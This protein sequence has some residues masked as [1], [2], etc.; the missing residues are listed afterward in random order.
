MYTLQLYNSLTNSLQPFK[1]INAN[2][3]TMYVCGPTVYNYIHVGNARPI[4]VFDVLFRLLRFIYGNNNVVYAT[5]FTD[6]DDKIMQQA[7]LENTSISNITTKYI[8]YYYADVANLNI[9]Q[10]NFQPKATQYIANMQ[11]LINTLLKN[12][13][14]YISNNTVYFNVKKFTN[15]GKISNNSMQNLLKGVRIEVAEN[16][17]NPL[18]F[19]LWKPS[20]AN[21][22]GWD[23]KEV[24]IYGRPGWHIECSAMIQALLGNTI[25][26]HAGGKD[27]MFPHHENENAQSCCANNTTTLANYWLHN[28]FI[29]VNGQKMSKS[30]GNFTTLNNLLQQYCGLTIKLALLSGNYRQSLDLS[31]NLLQ[32]SSKAIAKFT[33]AL[34]QFNSIANNSAYLQPNTSFINSLCTD[35]NTP[36]AIATL[37]QLVNTN[38]NASL[39]QFVFCANLLGLLPNT[40]NTTSVTSKLKIS[41]AEI[42][43]KIELRNLAK[44]NKNFAKAD[45]IRAELLTLGVKLI[46]TPTKTTW[47]TE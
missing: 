28:G 37:H 27:L 34:Q 25:D 45:E 10:P 8:N 30:L 43:Q 13:Y 9:L 47:H 20:D 36:K 32:Q 33:K 12:N 15:Y 16:K 19:V 24:N 21:Q 38:T 29:T 5:N 11:Q 7:K 23:F 14:A 44:A 1:P 3:V 46:D 6:I 41:P 39:G 31:T 22:E 26:I 40:T 17:T 35:L 4:V 18:D 2:N 42:E